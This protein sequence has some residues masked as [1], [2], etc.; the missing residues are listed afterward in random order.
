MGPRAPFFPSFRGRGGGV[1]RARAVVQARPSVG[2]PFRRWQLPAPTPGAGYPLVRLP[3][4]LSL[5]LTR[6]SRGAA[7]EG[8]SGWRGP[9]L[10]SRKHW[11]SG[12][13]ASRSRTPEP[14]RDRSPVVPPS[15]SPWPV[16]A[17]PAPTWWDPSGARERSYQ[18]WGLLCDS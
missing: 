16:G 3:I 13:P 14:Q 6:A 8:V 2:R 12:I 1:S 10:P 17:A 9:C 11:G 5:M 18:G 4:C 7:P 15:P